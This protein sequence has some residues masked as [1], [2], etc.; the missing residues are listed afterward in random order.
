MFETCIALKS[1]EDFEKMRQVC[2]DIA[3]KDETFKF[4]FSLGTKQGIER[5]LRVQSDTKNQAHQRGTWLVKKT[6]PGLL[7]WVKETRITNSSKKSS[8]SPSPPLSLSGPS[9]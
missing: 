9:T 5:V 3:K 2:L 4:S 6:I 7:Y 1:K 8:S